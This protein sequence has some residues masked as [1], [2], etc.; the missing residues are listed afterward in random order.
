MSDSGSQPGLD[1]LVKLRD[2]I[3]G[4][5]GVSLTSFGTALLIQQTRGREVICVDNGDQKC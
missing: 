4:P 3:F 5:E 2:E 1:Y